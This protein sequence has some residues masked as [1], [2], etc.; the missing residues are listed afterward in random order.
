MKGDALGLIPILVGVFVAACTG[1]PAAAPTAVVLPPTATPTQ[2]PIPTPIPPPMPTPGPLALMAADE[3]DCSPRTDNVIVS[4]R[5]APLQPK[6]TVT[7]LAS[8]ANPVVRGVPISREQV[9]IPITRSGGTGAEPPCE[10]KIMIEF[11]V[12]EYLKG[13][14]DS[15]IRLAIDVERGPSVRRPVAEVLRGWDVELGK[16]YILFLTNPGWYPSTPGLSGRNHIYYA[17]TQGR[18]LVDGGIVVAP[19]RILESMSLDEMR[20]IVA[21]AA[22]SP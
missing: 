5:D 9:N 22:N 3:A 12:S 10:W 14:G 11:E 2:T 1:A 4:V 17:G 15:L 20:A 6:L 8:G 7:Q 21:E 19:R 16:E 18:W 13:A